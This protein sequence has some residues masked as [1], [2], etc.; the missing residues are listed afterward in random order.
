MMNESS[1]KILNILK[2]QSRG[3]SIVE[4]SKL[5][6]MNRMTIGRK[7]ETLEKDGVVSHRNVGM[8]KL[9]YYE[10]YP[11]IKKLSKDGLGLNLK[12]MLNSVHSGIVIFS[13][14]YKPIWYNERIKKVFRSDSRNEI[15]LV[16]GLIERKSNEIIVGNKKYIVVRKYKSKEYYIKSIVKYN[17]G[18]KNEYL[19]ISANLIRDKEGNRICNFAIIDKISRNFENLEIK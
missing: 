2:N 15:E 17:N 10:K 4:I 16:K 7:L 5:T 13:E 18:S 11:I 19:F 1:Q 14:D 6:G 3:L 12:M 8:A 9:W